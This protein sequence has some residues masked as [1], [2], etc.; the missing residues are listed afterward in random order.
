MA[1]CAT[2]SVMTTGAKYPPTNP[3]IV[4]IYQSEKPTVA[5]EEIGR[6][7]VEKYNNLGITRSGDDINKALREKASAIGGD[8]IISVSEDFA[9]T[10]GVVVKFKK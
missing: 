9:S 4:K 3:A 7:S 5:Y 10:S 2:E 8:A 6:G 1:S